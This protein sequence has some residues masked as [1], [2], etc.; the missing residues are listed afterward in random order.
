MSMCSIKKKKTIRLKTLNGVWQNAPRVKFFFGI[1]SNNSAVSI[2]SELFVAKGVDFSPELIA[3]TLIII[4][5]SGPVIDRNNDNKE[6]KVYHQSSFLYLGF[7]ILF[8][9]YSQTVFQM[10]ETSKESLKCTLWLVGRAWYRQLYVNAV[11]P[12]N[13]V[14]TG[15]REP[16]V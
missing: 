2:G 15:R 4:V 7:K 6:C 1:K 5:I 14:W 16:V 11:W 13:H 9:L 12:W 3:F 10:M 8:S